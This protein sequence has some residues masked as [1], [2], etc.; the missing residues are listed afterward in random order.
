VLRR[1]APLAAALSV[2]AI[3]VA[4][5]LAFTHISNGT[6]PRLRLA[7]GGAGDS[8]VPAAAPAAEGKRAA[9]GSSFQLVGTLPSG[10]DTERAQSLPKGAASAAAVRRLADALG[11]TAEPARVEGAWQVGSLR[12]EDGAGGNGRRSR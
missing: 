8:G 9:I 1:W 6:P 7:A 10:P 3:A 2:V 11:V 4:V 12:V 5:S